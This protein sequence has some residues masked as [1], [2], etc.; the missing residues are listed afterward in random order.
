MKYIRG[1]EKE[2]TACG[3]IRG[4]AILFSLALAPLESR[5]QGIYSKCM[6]RKKERINEERDLNRLGLALAKTRVNRYG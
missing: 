1:P 6:G 4:R 2:K 5:T 3:A